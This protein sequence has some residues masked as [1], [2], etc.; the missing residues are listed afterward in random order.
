M[1]NLPARSPDAQYLGDGVYADV[2]E[3]MIRLTA[4]D[5]VGAQHTIYLEMDVVSALLEWIIKRDIKEKLR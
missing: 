3:G 5:G 2:E 1:P 4:E